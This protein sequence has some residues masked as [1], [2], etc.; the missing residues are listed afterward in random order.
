MKH[1]VISTFLFVI[2]FIVTFCASLTVRAQFTPPADTKVRL[3]N[4]LLLL[5]TSVSMLSALDGGDADCSSDT[6]P[7]K[8]RYT[9]LG[10]VLT[11]TVD[12][13]D[14][15]TTGDPLGIGSP[16]V[17]IMSNS[18]RKRSG[19]QNCVPTFNLDTDIINSLK[20]QPY[21]WPY[22]NAD[23]TN[24][25]AIAYCGG[26][27]AS[28]FSKCFTASEWSNREMCTKA[29]VGWSQAADGL[30]DTYNSKIRF[31]MMSFDSLSLSSYSTSVLSSNK[32]MMWWTPETGGPMTIT[33]DPLCRNGTTGHYCVFYSPPTALYAAAEWSYWHGG[34]SDIGSTWLT[35]VRSPTMFPATAFVG[36]S[37]TF[38]SSDVG[39]RNP[40]ALPHKG[41]MIGF[42][43]PDATVTDT[44]AHNDMVQEAVLGL[45]LNL[46]H[47]TPLAGLLRDAFE[48]VNNDTTSDGVTIPHPTTAAPT[49]VK[50]GPQ[51]DQYFADPA[52]C[53]ETINI[54]ISDGEPSRDVN[55][56]PGYWAGRMAVETEVNTL[57]LGIGLES[58]RWNNG[59]N[60]ETLS[61][62]DLTPSDYET[63]P[64]GTKVCTRDGLSWKFAD[65]SPHNAGLTT[66]DR[67]SIR[68]CC[69]LLEVAI[70]GDPLNKYGQT[71][72]FP[73]DQAAFKQALDGILKSIAGNTVSRTVPI[74]ANITSTFQ[75]GNAPATYYELRSAMIPSSKPTSGT[76]ERVRYACDNSAEPVMQDVEESK[77]DMF[78]RNLDA[79]SSR[80]RRFIVPIPIKMSSTFKPMWT[81]RPGSINTDWLMGT[82]NSLIGDF[83]RLDGSSPDLT[84]P[85]TPDATSPID[86]LS[87]T[88]NSLGGVS[89]T[90]AELL[91]IANSDRSV[92]SSQLGTNGTSEC[93]KRVLQWYGGSS[94]VY[95]LGGGKFSPSRD[96]SVCGGW[97]KCGPLGAIYH[98]NPIIVSPPSPNAAEQSY[99]N[100]PDSYYAMQRTRP[101]MLYAQSMD[102]MLHAFVLS[103]NAAPPDIYGGVSTVDSLENNELWSFIPPAILPQIWPNFKAEARLLDGP[104]V[105]G[106]VVFSRTMLQTQ[107]GETSDA[108]FRTVLVGSS[109][110]GDTGF[111]Y[112]LDVTNP[113]QPRFLWQLVN[114]SAGIPLF[115]KI[116]PGAAIT[117][118]KV[119][120]PKDGVTKQIGVA[121]LPGGRDPGTPTITRT[122]RI[123]DGSRSPIFSWGGPGNSYAPREV[124]RDWGD[125][126]PSRSV[127]VVELETGR[128]IA[129]FSGS[130]A[131]NPG[132]TTTIDCDGNTSGA[133]GAKCGLNPNIIINPSQVSFDS[134]MSGTPS[135][136]PNGTAQPAMR[137]YIGDA[138]GTMW[139]LDLHDDD[140]LKW[141]AEI[142]W[143]AY[144]HT[145]V[146]DNSFKNS[147]V[148]NGPS[149]GSQ[150]NTSVTQ[151]QAAIL[152]QPIEQQPIVS[153]D[154]NNSPTITFTTGDVNA[155]NTSAPGMMNFLVTFVDSNNDAG[156]LFTP[157][158]SAAQG[159]S[160]VFLDGSRV[161]GPTTL[162][163]SKLFFSYFSPGGS[164]VCTSGESGWC[165][166]DYVNGTN[167]FPTPILDI[168]PL[169]TGIDRCA[170][171]TSGEVVFGISVNAVPSCVQTEDDFNDQFLA[172][173]YNSYSSSKGLSYQLVMQTSQGGS[174]ENMSTVNTA[175]YSLPPP[176]ART[177]L[178]SWASVMQ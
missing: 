123:E 148:V 140:P 81:I 135:V 152:G 78:H 174:P 57:V 21:G 167:A 12:E 25:A 61:C 60:I 97:D 65:T 130:W 171:F 149:A 56:W 64:T 68:A 177:V 170:R 79:T 104:I 117:T 37:A 26:R 172:G 80:Q 27:N 99:S 169:T 13:L 144:N 121:I 53:R 36:P 141:T 72:Y 128:I 124:I 127:T 95:S 139:R 147:Y 63:S 143:D 157:T 90:A 33:S 146:P 55:D 125:K 50:I 38:V 69:T 22:E 107:N 166:V 114:T 103:K 6:D 175:R 108:G 155:F 105:A 76:L 43:H 98:S 41:R 29:A 14:C 34:G 51:M 94:Q 116:L 142:A 73:S 11:G 4:V 118:L 150:L 83:V 96:P 106:E 48:F 112:A 59:G 35:G 132:K 151:Q 136:F 87:S 75:T 129:R 45:G 46:E 119:K 145:S 100:G 39:A 49:L 8:A 16:P 154:G 113:L 160:M 70:N 1:K 67:S 66:A 164:S 31:G 115:G 126:L 86:T 42:G 71:P 110:Y 19:G 89:P 161:T 23:K 165:A 44:I 40:R 102:G 109:G 138:D 162:F 32:N 131:D 153:V 111:Y 159:I 17:P 133:D 2:A 47:S 88:I 91:N 62:S 10:E 122:R 93:A 74:F 156:T 20:A 178:Q 163:D 54:L 137:A 84:H 134:P 85:Y 173:Q 176:R 158:I 5:D 28:K 58:L 101:T 9:I 52:R 30:L 120:D 15:W 18:D 3:P 92:C 24:S 7:K 77:G 82:P 168:D